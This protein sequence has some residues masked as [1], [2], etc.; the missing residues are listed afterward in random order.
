MDVSQYLRLKLYFTSGSGM[1]T[2]ETLV[3]VAWMDVHLG[4][5]GDVIEQG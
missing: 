4:K 5:T 1:N 2:I 3:E